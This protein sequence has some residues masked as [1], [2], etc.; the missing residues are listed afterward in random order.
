MTITR[1]YDNE[2]W[3]YDKGAER[4][5]QGLEAGCTNKK[6]KFVFFPSVPFLTN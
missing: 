4:R 5:E 2:T 6:G 3:N 1:N